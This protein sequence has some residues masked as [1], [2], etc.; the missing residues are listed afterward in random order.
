VLVDYPDLGLL[1]RPEYLDELVDRRTGKPMSLDDKYGAE[2]PRTSTPAL[3]PSWQ[4]ARQ[5]LLALRLGQSTSQSVKDLSVGMVEVDK[6]CRWALD[7]AATGQLSFLLLESPYGMGKSHALAHLKHLALARIMAVGTVVLDGVGISLCQPMSL[8]S[9]LAHAIVFPGERPDEGLPERLAQRV[10]I[11]LDITGGETLHRLLKDMNRELVDDPDK[12]ERIEDYLSLD[13]SSA[14]LNR[15]LGIKAPSLRA[16]RRED[17]PRRC[18]TIIREWASACTVLGAR[19]G[20]VVLLD[21]ADVDYAQGGRTQNEKEQR[22]ELF[23]AFRAIA[24]ASPDTGGFARLVVA[25][26]ITP[27]ASEPDPVAELESTLGSHLRTVRL[28]ELTKPEMSELG[29][30]INSLYRAAYQLP[31]GNA[32]KMDETAAECL[33]LIS[34]HAEGRNPRKFIRLLLEKLDVAHA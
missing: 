19:N 25:L 34:E 32:A 6:A 33:S 13:A 23:Q 11:G 16:L 21:E 28:T 29:C 8:L 31:D 4:T 15:E 12:W 3:I 30:R 27:G 24:E 18:S 2:P 14:D 20:L 9:G 7:R 10:G 5:T 26:A 22:T 17:R 1:H